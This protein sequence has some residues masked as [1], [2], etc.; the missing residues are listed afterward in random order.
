MDP[1][2]PST[3]LVRSPDETVGGV[4]VKETTEIL[5]RVEAEELTDYVNI[6]MGSYHSFAKI[7]GGM[8]EPSGY[9]L[10]TSAPVA[11]ASTLPTMVIGRFRTLEEDRKSTRLKSSQQCESL[12]PTSA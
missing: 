6:S 8:H 4:G 10:A 12:M 1:L 3:T 5:A 11:R 9:E 7:I 2:L